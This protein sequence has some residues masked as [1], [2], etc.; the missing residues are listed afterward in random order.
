M[1]YLPSDAITRAEYD[2]HT[3]TLSI[4]FVKSGTPH[5]YYDVPFNTYEGL[6]QAPSTEQ[7][8]D[9][10]IRRRYSNGPVAAHFETLVR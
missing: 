2:P 6:L 4:W 7:Y 10:Q 1:P 9:T 8:F 5:D 3:C